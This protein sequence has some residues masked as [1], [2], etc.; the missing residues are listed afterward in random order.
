MPSIPSLRGPEAPGPAR[1]VAKDVLLAHEVLHALAL[2]VVDALDPELARLE[3]AVARGDDH[4]PRQGRASLV[5]ADR[6]QL[7]AVLAQALER[8][9]LLA[10]VHLGAVLETL[11]GAKLDELRALDPRVPG[12]V[13]DVLLRID[14]RD[15]AAELLQALAD[16]HG[17]VA[18]SGVVRGSETRRARPAA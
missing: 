8:P 2:P 9:H 14:G 4:R 15:L 17:S 7:L 6:E 11:L 12:D 3:G 1:A 10:E 18:V 13:V 5:G 16:P